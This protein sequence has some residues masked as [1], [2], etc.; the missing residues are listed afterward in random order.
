MSSPES[1]SE[2]LAGILTQVRQ[3]RGLSMTELGK[4]TGLSQQAISYIERGKRTPT[5]ETLYRIAEALEV[6]LA[7]LIQETEDQ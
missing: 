7:P 2:A 5:I 6:K 4:R 3:E 1:K